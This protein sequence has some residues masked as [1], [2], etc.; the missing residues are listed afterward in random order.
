M[1]NNFD[2]NA[3]TQTYVI[4]NYLLQTGEIV[5]P[6]KMINELES[7]RNTNYKFNIND[8]NKISILPD[9]EK[10]LT[11]VFLECVANSEEKKQINLLVSNLRKIIINEDIEKQIQQNAL[12]MNL[13]TLKWSEKFKIALKKL[14]ILGTPM[15]KVN[16]KLAK[17]SERM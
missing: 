10:L 3:Y 5:V 4:V 14:L 11:Y 7:K 2:K 15:N 1:E 12:P 17:S 8:I 13:T 6:E 16:K 9:T